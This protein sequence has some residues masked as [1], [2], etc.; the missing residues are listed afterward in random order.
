[1]GT[2]DKYGNKT[3]TVKTYEKSEI[4][5]NSGFSM[6][7]IKTYTDASGEKWYLKGVQITNQKYEGAKEE[8][9]YSF[10]ILDSVNSTKSPQITGTSKCND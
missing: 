7:N 4:K 10:Y 3:E 1:M 9:C 6:N 8:D 2:A 5:A